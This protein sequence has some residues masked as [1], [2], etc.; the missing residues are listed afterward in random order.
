MAE[1]IEDFEMGH[2]V[3]ETTGEHRTSWGQVIPRVAEQAKL[4]STPPPNPSPGDQVNAFV[5]AD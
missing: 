3:S 5:A 1:V 2:S 4:W